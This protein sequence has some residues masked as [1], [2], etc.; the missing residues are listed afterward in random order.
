MTTVPLTPAQTST[1]VDAVRVARDGF[2][3]LNA[4]GSLAQALADLSMLD[5]AVL[6]GD[7]LRTLL[8]DAGDDDLQTIATFVLAMD[9]ATSADG[10][11]VRKAFR[12]IAGHANT[13]L[14]R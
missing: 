9:A 8:P 6:P 7:T 14:G 3:F 11:K 10:G 13:V 1:L 12:R 4:A 2:A 5:P